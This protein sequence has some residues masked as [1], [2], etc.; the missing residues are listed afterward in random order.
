MKNMNK[1]EFCIHIDEIASGVAKFYEQT[2]INRLFTHC[3][4]PC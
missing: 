4:G 2:L 3:Q 1:G